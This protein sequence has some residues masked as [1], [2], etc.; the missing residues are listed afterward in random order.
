[1]HPE[2]GKLIYLPSNL[3]DANSSHG[4]T[5]GESRHS[6]YSGRRYAGISRGGQEIRDKR[7]TIPMKSHTSSD[8]DG[9][10]SG[11]KR[12]ERKSWKNSKKSYKSCKNRTGDKSSDDSSGSSSEASDDEKKRELSRRGRKGQ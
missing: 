8:E 4:R 7:E 11:E 3:G 1:M 5:N 10:E 12:R 2:N 6:E 9:S